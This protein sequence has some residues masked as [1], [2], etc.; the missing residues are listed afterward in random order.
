[1]T[2]A[3]SSHRWPI[4]LPYLSPKHERVAAAIAEHDLKVTGL[5]MHHYIRN[6][7]AA[8]KIQLP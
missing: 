1:V 6:N 2:F 3:R 4:I 7:C 5:L 8:L